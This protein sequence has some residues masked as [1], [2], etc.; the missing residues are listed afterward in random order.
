MVNVTA[1]SQ[2]RLVLLQF[3]VARCATHM[4]GHHG[5]YILEGE[6]VPRVDTDASWD[7][8]H[9]S[10]ES[11]KIIPSALLLRHL[12]LQNLHSS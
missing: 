3:L 7:L 2:P 5:S 1:V 12:W 6:T 11:G 10:H 9:F 8:Q 4:F